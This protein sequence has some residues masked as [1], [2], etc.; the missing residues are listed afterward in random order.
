M[1]CLIGREGKRVE[2]GRQIEMM[3]YVRLA[4]GANLRSSWESGRRTEVALVME[5]LVGGKPGLLYPG[6]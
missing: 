6:D 2:G 3:L 1:S 4:R 5:S